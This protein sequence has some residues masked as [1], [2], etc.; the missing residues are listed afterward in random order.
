LA[1]SHSHHYPG[2]LG[3]FR[4]RSGLQKFRNYSQTYLTLKR[5]LAECRKSFVNS[6]TN[7]GPRRKTRRTGLEATQKLNQETWNAASNLYWQSVQDP[8]GRPVVFENC[9]CS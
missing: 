3:R 5:E 6:K 8:C 2:L 1:K 7:T 9:R 4:S